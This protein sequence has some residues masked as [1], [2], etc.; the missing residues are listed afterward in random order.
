MATPTN[1][2]ETKKVSHTTKTT[3]I[4]KAG[5]EHDATFTLEERNGRLEVTSFTVTVK[6]D[7]GVI[8]QAL[9]RDLPLRPAVMAVRAEHAKADTDELAPLTL[10]RW[11][12]TP[13]QLE[14]VAKL[15]REAYSQ[16]K[17][18]QAYLS[19]KV[20]RPLPTVNRWIGVARKKGY[21]GVANGTRAGEA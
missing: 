15:Y 5:E 16:G 10:E 13:E 18:V 9:L 6:S 7:T 2:L 17:P 14:L 19:T 8:T 11:R 3:L 20:G 12:D 4:D 21:L 1:R